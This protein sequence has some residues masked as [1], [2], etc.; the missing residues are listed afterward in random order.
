MNAWLLGTLDSLIGLLLSRSRTHCRKLFTLQLGKQLLILL[1]DGIVYGYLISRMVKGSLSVAEFILFAGVASGISTWLSDLAEQLFNLKNNSDILSH[2]HLFMEKLP[3]SKKHTVQQPQAPVAN[4]GRAHELRLEHA[5]FQY[6]ES[7]GY[8]LEDVSLT[9]RPG[10]KLALV[11]ANGAGKSTLVKTRPTRPGF[12]KASAWPAWTKR[13]RACPRGWKPPCSGPWTKR[14]WSCLA[15]RCSGSCWPE[16]YTKMRPCF[17]RM[18]PPPPWTPLVN[19]KS[20]P[21]LATCSGTKPASISPT[22]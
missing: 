13:W 9:L 2:Y 7:K 16:P 22:A 6:P 8:A 15:A 1:R 3:R 18:N 12:V 14:A 11:G 4:P 5:Y 17:S 21:A 19:M 20:I 10:E